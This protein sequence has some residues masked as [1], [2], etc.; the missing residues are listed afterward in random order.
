MDIIQINILIYKNKNN[1]F[2]VLSIHSMTFLNNYAF[3]LRKRTRLS[4]YIYIYKVSISCTIIINISKKYY[5]KINLSHH[6]I[7]RFVSFL[8][9]CCSY[10]I[11]NGASVDWYTHWNTEND[12]R[13]PIKRCKLYYKQVRFAD[14]VAH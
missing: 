7:K 14:T 11:T 4:N 3:Q 9:N 8:F 5:E 12:K 13:F 2:C 6:E 10:I 1:S